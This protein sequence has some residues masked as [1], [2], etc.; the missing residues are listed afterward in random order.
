MTPD[1]AY[2]KLA[3]IV[4]VYNHVAPLKGATHDMIIRDA[5]KALSVFRKIAADHKPALDINNTEN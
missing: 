3:S 5:N 1:E 2:K 4:D